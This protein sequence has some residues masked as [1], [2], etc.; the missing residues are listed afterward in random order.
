[1]LS[2]IPVASLESVINLTPSMTLCLTLGGSQ[3]T[4]RGPMQAQG[5]HVNSTKRFSGLEKCYYTWDKSQI[6]GVKDGF[7][8]LS[9][10]MLGLSGR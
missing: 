1:M 5:E 2:I 6:R 8:H 7:I 4:C 10:G 3:T 9:A